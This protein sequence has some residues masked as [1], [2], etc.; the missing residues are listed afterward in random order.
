MH[1]EGGNGI[2]RKSLS[3]LFNIVMSLKPLEISK[4]LLKKNF[5][6]PSLK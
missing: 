5:Y 3:L 2:W 1:G 6:V 4:G